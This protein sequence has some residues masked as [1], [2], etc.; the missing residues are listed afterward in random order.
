VHYSTPTCFLHALS[1]EKRSWPVREGDFM[2]Y[3]HRAHAF[4]TGFYTSR[5]GIKFYE[6]SLG[7]LYQVSLFLSNIKNKISSDIFCFLSRFDN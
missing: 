4:W 5:P 7:A 1:K 2:S 3:A 6:R